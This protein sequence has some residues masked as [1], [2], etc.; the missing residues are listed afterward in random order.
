MRLLACRGPVLRSPGGFTLLELVTVL[1]IVALLAGI[2]FTGGTMAVRRANLIHCQA[3]LL[4]LGL[5]IRAYLTDCHTLP[6]VYYGSH[7]NPGPPRPPSPPPD[8]NLAMVLGG[9]VNDHDI[10]ECPVTHR[11][12]P[13]WGYHVNIS[14]SGLKLS[15]IKTPPHRAMIVCDRFDWNHATRTGQGGLENALFLDGHVKAYRSVGQFPLW[16][17][18]VD[19]SPWWPYD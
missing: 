2:I 6:L 7:G 8:H 13:G 15:Q 18:N 11:F 3:N 4:Q 19:G 16:G 9:Y 10:F 5:A 17:P 1:G 14:G 12:R